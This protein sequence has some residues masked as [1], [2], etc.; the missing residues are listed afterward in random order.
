MNKYRFTFNLPKEEDLIK[1][2][3]N[4]EKLANDIL[5]DM[6]KKYPSHINKEEIYTKLWLIGRSYSAALERNKSEEK[7]ENIYLKTIDE[8]IK[9]GKT[10]DDKIQK[11]QPIINDITLYS[12][13][14]V[15]KEIVDIFH[16]TTE[17]K[18]RSLASKY[19]HFHR[20]D[21]FYIY[22]SNASYSLKNCVKGSI[23]SNNSYDNDYLKFC[24]KAFELK[25]KINEN[26]NR[27]FDTRQIDNLLLYLHK[28]KQ[29]EIEKYKKVFIDKGEKEEACECSE[30]EINLK[31]YFKSKEKLNNDKGS[32][33]DESIEKKGM[34]Y[35]IDKI[36]ETNY[37]IILRND[38]KKRIK[39]IDDKKKE[40]EIFIR[41]HKNYTRPNLSKDE[42]KI[43]EE[44]Y[45]LIHLIYLKDNPVIYIIPAR[46]WR[47]ESEAFTYSKNYNEY[48]VNY[49]QKNMKI[50]D[51]YK[52]NE[53][54]LM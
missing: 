27:D 4:I 18:N 23:P 34:K 33:S 48:G 22:D 53:I 39:I 28:N 46:V 12:A 9:I 40:F 7:S 30:D 5:Y 8:L 44:N 36:K 3:Y 15:H 52:K 26:F 10:L 32:N 35:I 41:V 38:Q 43:Y 49:S 2:E 29:N 21:V 20:P 54:I 13:L 16:K 25:M 24:K 14:N 11:L 51:K 47:E 45:Y 19:L 42:F 31:V 1:S 50:I 6:C 37:E 17:Q